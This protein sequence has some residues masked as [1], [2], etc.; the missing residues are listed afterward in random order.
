M[1]SSI[2]NQVTKHNYLNRKPSKRVLY[3][4]TLIINSTL[5]ED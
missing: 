1:K 5:M 2:K 4:Y 3:Y